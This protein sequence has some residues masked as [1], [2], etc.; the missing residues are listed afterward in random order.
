MSPGGDDLLPPLSPLLLEGGEGGEPR[1]GGES[2]PPLF[3]PFPLSPP[4][5]CDGGE[6][7]LLEELGGE[8]ACGAGGDVE[9]GGGDDDESP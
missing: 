3:P 1:D 9:S 8:G 7:E 6:G 5:P 2:F 4:P